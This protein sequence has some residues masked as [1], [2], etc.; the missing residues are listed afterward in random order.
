MNIGVHLASYEYIYIIDSD[1]HMTDDGVELI[2]NWI[3]TID[4][5]NG[6]AGVSGLRG[7]NK[8]EFIGQYPNHQEYIDATNLDRKKS[9]LMGDKAEVY[10]K[11][12]LIK[13]PFPEFEEERFIEESVV[14]D[15][16]AFDGFKIR[17]FNEVI[18]ICEYLEDGLTKNL[19]DTVRLDNF[20]GYTLL[21]K[22]NFMFRKFPHNYLSIGRYLS[23][24]KHKGYDRADV[25]KNLEINNLD[26]FVGRLFGV[27]R[28]VIKG[29]KYNERI[30]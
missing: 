7:K 18:C 20:E 27:L 13:Y 8:S 6:F 28:N 19:S 5:D 17:W 29:I 15:K 12:I 26:Y 1:D 14:W 3:K 10:K 4:G 21:E 23:L 30:K 25:I 16:I 2:Y 11:D 24:A 22:Q 9:K